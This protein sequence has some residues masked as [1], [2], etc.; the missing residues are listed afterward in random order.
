L[1]EAYQIDAKFLKNNKT[2]RDMILSGSEDGHLYGWDLNSQRLQIK[3][4]IIKDA[5]IDDKHGAED[6]AFYKINNMDK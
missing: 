6:M 4:P 3:L 1:N 2:G 5:I